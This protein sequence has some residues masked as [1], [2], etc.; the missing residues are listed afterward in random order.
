MKDVNCDSR[1]T[2]DGD[3][4]SVEHMANLVIS[5]SAP[6]DAPDQ[7]AFKSS[8]SV[9][10]LSVPDAH[11]QSDYRNSPRL[12]PRLHST[13]L[14]G[15]TDQQPASVAQAAPVT[16]PDSVDDTQFGGGNVFIVCCLLTD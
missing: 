13:R 11:D 6:S 4:E 8:P 2:V 3:Y 12:P 5:P 15:N 9:S 7:S 10:A 16:R 14:A 1:L